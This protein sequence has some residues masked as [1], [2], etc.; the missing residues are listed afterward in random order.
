MK[1]SMLLLAVIT[2]GL[3][4]SLKAQSIKEEVD[5]L[6]S[7]FGMEKKAMMAE[8][9]ADNA[10][11]DFWA[12]YDEYETQRKMLGQERLLLLAAYV[13]TYGTLSDDETLDLTKA[14]DKHKK[15]LDKLITKYYKKVNKASGAKV[16]AQFYQFENYILSYVRISVLESIP[17]IGELE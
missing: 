15:A 8:F 3:L 7:A 9:V 13:Y 14:M 11:K 10:N 16:A 4:G 5:F 6:Q 12:I 17:F 2:F 1:K